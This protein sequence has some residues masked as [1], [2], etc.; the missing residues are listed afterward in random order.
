MT[1]ENIRVRSVRARAEKDDI[2]YIRI[3]PSTSR[4]PKA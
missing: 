2:A 1:R 3:T 4:P